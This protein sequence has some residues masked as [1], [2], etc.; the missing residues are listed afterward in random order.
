MKT[1]T[2]EQMD[3][4]Q[5]TPPVALKGQG[6]PSGTVVFAVTPVDDGFA[7]SSSPFEFVGAPEVYG[8][9]SAAV[10]R[11]LECARSVAADQ[12]PPTRREQEAA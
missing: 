12:F 2:P 9:M 3:T 4:A 7:V 5:A 6:T 11:M 1:L 8:S 10:D